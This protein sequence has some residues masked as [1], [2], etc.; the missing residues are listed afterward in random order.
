MKKILRTALVMV[1]LLGSFAT[2]KAATSNVDGGVWNYGR[3]ANSA[4]SRYFHSHKNHSS[5]V[6][7]SGYNFY[8]GNASPNTW[9][10]VGVAVPI[11]NSSFS[12]AYFYNV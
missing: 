6:Q 10:E 9:S 7:R 3:N 4:Y 1:M 5:T 12:W 2:M 11:W 8:S